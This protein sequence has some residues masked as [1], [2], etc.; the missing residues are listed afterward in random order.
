MAKDVSGFIIFFVKMIKP[1]AI[2]NVKENNKGRITS[3]AV[4]GYLW[5]TS[6]SSMD[7]VEACPIR[8]PE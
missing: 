3:S 4:D 6:Q 1:N 2:L 7:C 8:G 5:E